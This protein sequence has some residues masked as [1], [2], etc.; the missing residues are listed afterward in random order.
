MVSLAIKLRDCF[1]LRK[2]IRNAP[3]G[4]CSIDIMKNRRAAVIC[5]D[6]P[7]Q[8]V[9]PTQSYLLELQVR[10]A[11]GR[12]AEGPRRTPKD[13]ERRKY[14]NLRVICIIND[15]GAL[16][17]LHQLIR[18]IQVLYIF[19]SFVPVIDKNA[20]CL[21]NYALVCTSINVNLL[22]RKGLA[23]KRAAC[24]SVCYLYLLRRLC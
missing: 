6:G 10:D 24:A 17:S 13:A 12:A 8:A 9:R 22:W 11:A 14:R 7:I 19:L 1:S 23:L 18:H 20:F 15:T 16:G 21:M 5:W 2:A 4:F 3:V